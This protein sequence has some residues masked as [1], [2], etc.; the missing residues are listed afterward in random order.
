MIKKLFLSLTIILL[1]S[2][3]VNSA[4]P[5]TLENLDESLK[6]NVRTECVP[7]L[8][9]VSTL[10]DASQKIIRA[11]FTATTDNT[12]CV[13]LEQVSIL[14]DAVIEQV[15]C[16]NTANNNVMIMK[17]RGIANCLRMKKDFVGN[18]DNTTT[19][20]T[21]I[22]SSVDESLDVDEDI[23]DYSYTAATET[24]RMAK[25][26]K[27]FYNLNYRKF[28]IFLITIDELNDSEKDSDGFIYK[29]LP[30]KPE[31]AIGLIKGAFE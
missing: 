24:F 16:G 5:S 19:A 1:L 12:R 15:K 14:K 2:I 4:D 23:L 21:V 17:N 25:G 20:S 8:K 30:P 3:N 31:E 27:S 28:K 10:C 18:G 22:A 26:L 7:L 9:L 29:P 6:T 11:A 13:G